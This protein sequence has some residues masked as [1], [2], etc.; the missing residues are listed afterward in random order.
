MSSRYESRGLACLSPAESTVTREDIQ[1]ITFAGHYTTSAPSVPSTV[2]PHNIFSSHASRTPSWL[3]YPNG[4]M[5]LGGY[6]TPQ[7][8]SSSDGR[9]RR[10]FPAEKYVQVKRHVVSVYNERFTRVL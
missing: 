7:F 1:F 10:D 9:V 2:P 4:M 3:L 8:F 5:F 6:G